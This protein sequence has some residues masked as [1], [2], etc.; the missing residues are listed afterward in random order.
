MR[1]KIQ[2]IYDG[3]C[4]V[5][6][7]PNGLLLGLLTE[8]EVIDAIGSVVSDL[9]FNGAVIRRFQIQQIQ[10][11]KIQYEEP[12]WMLNTEQ[13]LVDEAH[14]WMQS[15]FDTATANPDWLTSLPGRPSTYRMDQQEQKKI[16]IQPA[17]AFSGPVVDLIDGQPFY[18]TLAEQQDGFSIAFSSSDPYYGVLSGDYDSETYLEAQPDGFGVMENLVTSDGNL[19]SFGPSQPIRDDDQLNDFL[20][21]VPNSF[22]IYIKYGALARIFTDNSELKDLNRA[23]YCQQRF[24]EGCRILAAVNT[25]LLYSL[26]VMQS[27][28]R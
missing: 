11:G 21:D 23:K 20:A 28:K 10:F 18:G 12:D 24:E 15:T 8:R 5:V 6:M 7:E 16:S 3:I 1:Q 19:M 27:G 2:K 22:L 9:L 25:D 17:P 4:R 14:L 13:C 26:T